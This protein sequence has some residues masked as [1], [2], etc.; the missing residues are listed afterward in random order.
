[1]LRGKLWFLSALI[2]SVICL[3]FVTQG[4]PTATGKIKFVPYGESYDDKPDFAHVEDQYPMR[5]KALKKLTPK[6]LERF[7]QEQLDQ[8]YARLTAGPIPDGPF[9]GTLI[10]ARGTGIKR[11]GEVLG[12]VKE[13][14]VKYKAKKLEIIGEILWKGKVFYRN[15]RVLRNRIQDLAILKPLVEGDVSS[16][17]KVKVRWRD[18]WLLFPAKVYCGQSLLDGRRESIIIDY[19]FSDEIEGYREQP[20]FLTGR[21]GFNLREEIRMI[22]PGFYLGRVYMDRFFVLTFAL[23]NREIAQRDTPSFLEGKIEEDC[24]VGTQ[25]VAAH[26]K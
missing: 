12:G 4:R 23:Y 2:L 3:A 19:A 17:P 14:A 1:M 25:R 7:D 6:Y 15:E 18:A 24:W 8:L 9:D 22:R 5:R 13:L 20:D 26:M 21:R 10:F 11:I 16:I